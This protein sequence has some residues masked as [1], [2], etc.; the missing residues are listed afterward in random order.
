ME[1]DI[2]EKSLS[3][4]YSLLILGNAVFVKK[5]VGTFLFPASIFSLF[6]F[7]YTFFPLILVPIPTE[8]LAIF[9]ILLCTIMF[10]ASSLFFDWEKAFYTNRIKLT[11]KEKALL[12]NN[13]FLKVVFFSIQVIVI[14][15]LIINLYFQG[16][17]LYDIV[18]NTLSSANRYMTMRYSGSIV[19]NV[20]SQFALIFN[21]IGVVLG[22]ILLIHTKNLKISILII[23]MSFLPS[24]MIMITQAAKGYIFLSSVLFYSGVLIARI[25]LGDIS[26]TNKKTNKIILYIILFLFPAL[27]ISFLSRGIYQEDSDV[28]INKLIYYFSSYAFG[29][30]FAFSDW[31][32]HYINGSSLLQYEPTDAP[33][34]GFY[35]FMSIFKFFGTDITVPSGTYNDY[36]MYENL[37]KT[38]IYTIYRGL[39]LD[40]GLYGTL[41]FWFLLGV[42]SHLAFYLLLILKRPIV[43]VVYFSVMLGFFY[44]SYLISLLMWNSIF[45]SGIILSIILFIN[46][47]KRK[48]NKC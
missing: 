23:V 47:Y 34:F 13:S 9:F 48:R 24:V 39:I 28:V 37:I 5:Y 20:F 14:L 26:L 19:P 4:L 42:L 30:V 29:H 6:W 46:I 3:I 2:L 18:F 33:Y 16:F 15:F 7:A 17:S 12:Y 22:G 31:F 8:P 21:Y 38:N 10:T 45:A 1:I 41:V 40:F 32:S 11:L 35:T 44:M 27:V 36:Y 25:N 43:P